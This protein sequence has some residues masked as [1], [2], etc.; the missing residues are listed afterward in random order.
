V[1]ADAQAV[2]PL[3]RRQRGQRQPGSRTPP[4]QL[5]CLPPPP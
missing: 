5:R 3:R 2:A 4:G 1:G